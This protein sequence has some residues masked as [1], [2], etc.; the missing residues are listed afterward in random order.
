MFN[1][2]FFDNYQFGSWSQF[3]DLRKLVQA[4]EGLD[5]KP[6]WDQ[7]GLNALMVELAQTDEVGPFARLLLVRKWDK[8]PTPR[9]LAFLALINQQEVISVMVDSL[10]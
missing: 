10:H 1:T 8:V 3:E 7:E 4:H 6:F 9:K 2:F 5:E